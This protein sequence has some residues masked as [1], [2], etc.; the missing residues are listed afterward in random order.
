MLEARVVASADGANDGAA[1]TIVSDHVF[2]VVLCLGLMSRPKTAVV[3]K[4]LLDTLRQHVDPSR[5]I[6][7]LVSHQIHDLAIVKGAVVLECLDHCLTLFVFGG[8]HEVDEELPTR[9][10]LQ[11]PERSV[12]PASG[13]IEFEDASQH[14]LT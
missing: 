5:P 13:P 2:E 3:S 4:L 1:H 12:T 8:L 6:W 14:Q 10:I 11:E 9:D 7:R